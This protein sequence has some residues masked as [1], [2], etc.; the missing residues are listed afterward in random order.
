MKR[1]FILGAV[2]F[3]TL[4]SLTYV[5]AQQGPGKKANKS[6]CAQKA[7]EMMFVQNA[8]S[9][10]LQKL[11]GEE[12]IYVLKLEGVSAETIAFSDR[13]ARVV[14]PIP[15]DKLLKSRLF[16]SKDAPNAA[17]E[18][19]GAD[20][21][22]DVM[23]VV[24]STPAYDAEKG[25][26]QY[27]VR[28]L[29]EPKHGRVVFNKRHDRSLPETFGPVALFIDSLGL[30]CSDGTYQCCKGKW[31]WSEYCGDIT[32]VPCC[33]HWTEAKCDPCDGVDL[34]KRC[35]KKYGEDCGYA[36]ASGGYCYW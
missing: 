35:K 5:C 17:I 4:F 11:K 15:T 14:V 34:E 20:E 27:I 18:I 29:K 24:L 1:F 22:A 10:S 30:S 16:R 33:W 8:D 23:V 7:V 9:G 13:P 31:S 19:L 2:F 12:G 25:T 21:G 28:P 3:V 36:H 6:Q 32:G 26:L